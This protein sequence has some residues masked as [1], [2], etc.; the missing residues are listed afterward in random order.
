MSMP[1]RGTLLQV[2]TGG[3]W[4]TI[5]GVQNLNTGAE[6]EQVDLTTIADPARLRQPALKNMGPWSCTLLWD[7]SYAAHNH[8]SGLKAD[9]NTGALKDYRILFTSGKYEQANC[10]VQNLSAAL[11]IGDHIK[12]S[13]QLSINGDVLYG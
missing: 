5:A 7:D 2:Y 13:L 4:V 11:Q 6:N 8:I 10:S 1:V 9:F 12:V 3:N